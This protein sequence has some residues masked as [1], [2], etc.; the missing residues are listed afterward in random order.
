MK[1]RPARPSDLVGVLSLLAEARLPAAGVAEHFD[2]FL[3]AEEGSRLLGAIGLERYPPVGLLRSAVVAASQR[4]R[5]IGEA[6]VAALVER[7]RGDHIREL[8]LLTET[9]EEWF[10]RRGFVRRDRGEAP[11]SLAASEEF[12]GACPESA[13]CLLLQLEGP[14]V[15]IAQLES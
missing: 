15:P 3:V 10:S 6:L 8:W 11:A 4:G 5:G 9:A 2:A 7:S 13:A 1:I 12:R 14:N